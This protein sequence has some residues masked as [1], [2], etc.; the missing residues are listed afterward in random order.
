M[1]LLGK[2]TTIA[3]QVYAK[4]PAVNSNLYIG[5]FDHLANVFK[6]LNKKDIKRLSFK[7]DSKYKKQI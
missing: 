7:K 2:E 5:A 4:N 1:K 6:Y 3:N